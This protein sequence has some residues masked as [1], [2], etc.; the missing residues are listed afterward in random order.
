MKKS[1]GSASD[2]DG[3]EVLTEEDQQK[4][5]TAWE[6]GKVADEDI[7]ETARKPK[8]L[9]S[10]GEEVEVRL[11]SFVPAL[12]DDISKFWGGADFVLQRSNHVHILTQAKPKAKPKKRVK[13]EESDAEEEEGEPKAKKAPAAKKVRFVFLLQRSPL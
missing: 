10:D 8:E 12:L 2:I 4:V 1:L 6:E 11:F 5:T 3:F 13:K 9:N 7:P